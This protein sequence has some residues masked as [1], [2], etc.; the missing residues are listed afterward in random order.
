MVVYIKNLSKS[1]AKNDFLMENV[2]FLSKMKQW[3]AL[4][5]NVELFY[6]L[7]KFWKFWKNYQ[8]LKISNFEDFF[9]KAL[10]KN[11]KKFEKFFNESIVIETHVIRGKKGRYFLA[12]KPQVL[13]LFIFRVMTNLIFWTNI[14]CKMP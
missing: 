1:R 11:L 6:G 12:V 2:G 14:Y 4:K 10:D 7:M 13:I 8:Y 5:I 9:T 3:W